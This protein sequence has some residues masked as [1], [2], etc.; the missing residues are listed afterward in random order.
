MNANTLQLDGTIIT[1]NGV[2]DASD[3][4]YTPNILKSDLASSWSNNTGLPN[5][6]VGG[7]TGVSTEINTNIVSTGV[8]VD[9]NGTYTASGLEHFD[10]PANGQLRHLAQ[11]PR[12][13]KVAVFGIIDGGS[14]DEVSLKIVV[15]DDSASSFIDYKSVV[16]VINNFQGGR[17]VAY[18][19]FTDNIIL[20]TNDYVKIMVA[21]ISDTT[22]VTAEFRYRIHN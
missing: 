17:D 7:E 5:T 3:S 9:L 20:D 1:R 6:F 21:N 12:E 14:N 16:R 22:D 10:A 11:S 2:S 13:F 8:F 19:N 15:W 4:N 18:F